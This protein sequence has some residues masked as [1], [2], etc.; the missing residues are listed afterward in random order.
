M[1][2]ICMIAGEAS[3]D[4]MGSLLASELHHRN[5]DLNLW[6][7]GGRRMRQSGVELLED[8]S[9]WGAI[10]IV[11]SLKVVPALLLALHRLKNALVS[12]KPD[13]L[14]LIDFGAFNT[15]VARK[16]KE[17]R[18]PVLYFFPPGSWRRNGIV[19]PNF[20]KLVDRVAT[21]FP[22]SEKALQEGGISAKF[23]G[24][25]LLD[26]VHPRIN[27]EMF[28]RQYQLKSCYPIVGLLPGSRKQELTNI[29]P[30]QLQA[31]KRIQEEYPSAA[32]VIPLASS[33]NRSFV[34]S[35]IRRYAPNLKIAL[36]EGDTYSAISASDFLIITS[37]TA[38]LEAAILEKPMVIVYR[39][40]WMTHLEYHLR[41]MNLPMI[42][43]P[44]ILAG[45]KFVP[46][47]IQE[48]ANGNNIANHTLRFLNNPDQL[49]QMVC[50]LHKLKGCLGEPGAI[51]RVAQMVYEMGG[52]LSTSSHDS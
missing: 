22:W 47:L 1:K 48:E 24:H 32:F 12:R 36:V 38:T 40:S 43:L 29:L 27:K 23:V 13:L 5:P 11:E 6:G 10:G 9:K 30:V 3:G 19:H 46:E 28:C 37:G 52:S 8:A 17:L 44:N 39:G 33:V 31:G 49:E 50:C 15:K 4:L 20:A 34:E 51:L 7:M 14:I 21:P 18:I 42:G 2:N 25:P 35:Q 16:A 26:V 41:R 45:E